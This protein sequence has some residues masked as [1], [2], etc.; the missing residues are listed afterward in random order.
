M[1]AKTSPSE[2]IWTL[3]SSLTEEVQESARSKVKELG[4]KGEGAIVGFNE[5]LVNLSQ[6]RDLVMDLI[7]KEKFNQIP[8]SIQAILQT[9]FETI[10][11]LLSDFSSG[12]DNVVALAKSVEDLY[13]LVWQYGLHKITDKLVGY[14]KKMTQLKNLELETLSLRGTLREGLETKGALDKLTSA[15]EST[16]TTAT[17]T[18]K[19]IQGQ[20]TTAKST[21]QEIARANADAIVKLAAINENRT[22]IQDALSK[23]ETNK[24]S[25][26]NITE[27]IQAFHKQIAD[28][29]KI[30]DELKI[31]AET[32]VAGNEVATKALLADLNAQREQITEQLQKATGVSLFKSFHARKQA[33][34]KSKWIWASGVIVALIGVGWLT[35]HLAKEAVTLGTGGGM[36]GGIDKLFYIKLTIYAPLAYI[37]YFCTKNYGHER[38]LEEEYAFKSNISLSLTAY[39]ELVEKGIENEKYADF[40]V[41]T[42][43]N[44]F[45]SPTDKVFSPHHDGTAKLPDNLAGAM[46]ILNK[47]VELSK[48]TSKV[49]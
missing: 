21:V 23:V 30:L 22:Q 10:T 49:V 18:L 47:L 20:E 37:I 36:K 1:D 13:A 42:I 45:S 28:N 16:S 32:A 25:V 26:Q 44:I 29:K 2:T 11:K 41:A 7:E 24:S 27:A 35:W 5:T 46:E 8:I 12:T 48:N 34:V 4:F 39:K 31:N 33:I 9:R 19:S 38:R 15:I 3:A 17:E 6:L 40:L 43:G 14:E